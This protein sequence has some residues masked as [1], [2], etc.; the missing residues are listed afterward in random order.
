MKGLEDLKAEV[1]ELKVSVVTL[2]GAVQ[3]TASRVSSAISAIQAGPSDSDLESIATD[4][5]GEKTQLDAVI[6]ALGNIVPAPAPAAPVVP[7]APAADAAP[8]DLAV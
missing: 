8:A 7:E 2:A 4:L 6:V 1:A 3:A 5:A